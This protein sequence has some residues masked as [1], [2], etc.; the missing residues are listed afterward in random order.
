MRIDLS[1]VELEYELWAL[2][3]MLETIEPAIKELSGQAEA[4]TLSEIRRQGWDWDDGAGVAFQELSEK[5]EYVLP[6]FMRGPFLVALWACFESGVQSVAKQRGLE[7]DARIGLAELKGDSFLKRARR[8]FE[9]ILDLPL[10]EDRGRYDRLVDLYRI[11]CALAHANGM[12]E[13][14]SPQEWGKLEA[15]L[16]RRGMKPDETRGMV[17]PTQEYVECAYSDVNGSLLDLV[18][19]ARM[20]RPMDSPTSKPAA[21]HA[22]P[23]DSSPQ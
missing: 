22:R 8:Y 19:R 21:R 6:R 13:G 20:N 16:E 10:D 15:T 7:V 12:R 9:A 11:R 4:Q 1:Y 23:A 18:T 5:R 14:M 17:I 2:G 3:H